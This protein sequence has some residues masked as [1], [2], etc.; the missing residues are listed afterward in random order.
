[1]SAIKLKSVTGHIVIETS[2]FSGGRSKCHRGPYVFDTLGLHFSSAL[3]TIILDKRDTESQAE[4]LQ[5]TENYIDKSTDSV[6]ANLCSA[7]GGDFTAVGKTSATP[8]RNGCIVD[9][10]INSS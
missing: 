3:K 7:S 8:L 10:L 9:S 4:Y 2:Y 5:D 1:M 6:L